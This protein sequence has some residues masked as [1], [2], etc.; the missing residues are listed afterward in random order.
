MLHVFVCRHLRWTPAV[1]V[2]QER[3]KNLCHHAVSRQFFTTSPSLCFFWDGDNPSL[4]YLTYLSL[5][6]HL[7][8][9]SC[10]LYAFFFFFFLKEGPMIIVAKAL[11]GVP[12]T[13]PRVDMLVHPLLLQPFHSLEGW[14]TFIWASSWSNHTYYSLSFPSL[15]FPKLCNN[16]WH[17]QGFL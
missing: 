7:S 10:P 16:S 17:V 12:V 11:S 13:K 1:L 14:E 15:L 4:M 3:C 8:D 6:S 9:V 5:S 2:S